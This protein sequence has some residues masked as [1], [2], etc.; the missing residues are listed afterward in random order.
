[1]TG[2][3]QPLV[4]VIIPCRNE[5][6]FIEKCIR[7]V[8][9]S[10]YPADKIEVLV[11]D[12]MSIDGTREIVERLCEQDN[13]VSLYNNEQK[14]VPTAMNIGIAAAKGQVIIRVDGH[15]VVAEDFIKE[16]VRRLQNHPEAWCVG[17]PIET[18]SPTY[19]G[20][21]IAVAMSSP[22]GVG[23]AMFRLGNY[24]GFVDTIAFGVY[25]RWVLTG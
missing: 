11:V 20:K 5:G 6:D 21:A 1:M 3:E 7:S 2:K 23:N 8:L 13:R 18:V 9:N 17:G 12:G 19:I 24:E 16:S 15:V 14:I 22:V 4:S 10:E 25:W